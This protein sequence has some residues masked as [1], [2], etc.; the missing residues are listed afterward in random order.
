MP[1]SLGVN[2]DP[3]ILKGRSTHFEKGLT[4]FEVKRQGSSGIS[5]EVQ[6][7][8]F[9]SSFD[10][11]ETEAQDHGMLCLGADRQGW[12]E[13]HLDAQSDP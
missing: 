6:M 11:R 3:R 1:E 10:C 4:S 5:L 9:L 8:T 12:R 13:Q 2:S 7:I